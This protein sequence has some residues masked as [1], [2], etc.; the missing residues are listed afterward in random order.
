[1]LNVAFENYDPYLNC[2]RAEFSLGTSARS[3]LPP[4]TLSHDRENCAP[5]THGYSKPKMRFG[6]ESSQPRKRK[7]HDDSL[8]NPQPLHEPEI[9]LRHETKIS[10][11]TPHTPRMETVCTHD[12]PKHGKQNRKKHS[13]TRNTPQNTPPHSVHEG[14]NH[15]HH[16]RTP[17]DDLKFKKDIP[18][19]MYDNCTHQT[20]DTLSRIRRPL[21]LR[22][23]N[24]LYPHLLHEHDVTLIAFANGQETLNTLYITPNPDLPCTRHYLQQE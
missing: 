2:H 22:F 13:Q 4:S 16:N 24:T 9:E 11:N 12:S 7:P 21:W 6:E 19:N 14:E 23:L 5:T 17:K 18:R 15:L 3:R 20:P 10:K 8:P 1:M